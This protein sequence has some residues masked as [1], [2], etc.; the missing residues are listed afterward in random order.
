MYHLKKK[1]KIHCQVSAAKF[2]KQSMTSI[3]G[4]HLPLPKASLSHIIPKCMLLFP[5]FSLVS[6][7]VMYPQTIQGGLRI[8]ILI[9]VLFSSTQCQSWYSC[10]SVLSPFPEPVYFSSIQTLRVRP[11]EGKSQ[12]SYQIPALARLQASP[13]A[14]RDPHSHEGKSSR[15]PR[16]SINLQD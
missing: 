15:S 7:P 10:V 4:A 6:L 11:L 16:F 14:L 3:L 8:D 2:T 1:N 12:A 9:Q 13:P 5:C